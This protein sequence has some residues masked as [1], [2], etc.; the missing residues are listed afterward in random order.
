M[1]TG[2]GGQTGDKHL[3]VVVAVIAV[4]VVVVVYKLTRN[5][6][7]LTKSY[8]TQRIDVKLRCEKDEIGPVAQE[9]LKWPL[10]TCVRD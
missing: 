3:N 10:L 7:E 5:A 9:A 8:E 4:A 1:L 6:R 2:G